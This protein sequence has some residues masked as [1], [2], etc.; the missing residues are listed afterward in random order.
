MMTKKHYEAIAAQFRGL[1]GD[2]ERQRYEA[3][4]EAE[5][6]VSALDKLDWR[7]REAS[8]AHG[9]YAVGVLA[10]NLANTFALDNP[11][12]DRERWDYACDG[13]KGERVARAIRESLDKESTMT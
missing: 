8:M 9:I 4:M 7:A 13:A 10:D 12:F 2:L 1:T 6:H 11:R 5:A 3:Q